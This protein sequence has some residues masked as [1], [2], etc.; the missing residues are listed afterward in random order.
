[1]LAELVGWYA[2]QEQNR[3]RYP[4]IRKD[5]EA[6]Y[7][8]NGGRTWHALRGVDLGGGG[9][10][11]MSDHTI[12]SIVV[13]IVLHLDEEVPV[14]ALPV[15][16]TQVNEGKKTAYCYGMQFISIDARHWEAVMHWIT[17]KA[18]E[19]DGKMPAVR[20]SDAEVA[21]L[22]PKDLRKN[23]LAEL[24]TRNR[25]DAANQGTLQFDYGGVTALNGKPMHRFTLHS[26]AKA[27][28]IEMRYTT[29]I[30]CDDEGQEIIVL[31]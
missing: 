23:L 10:C 7:S 3:R 30:L 16:N 2:G 20:I 31:N 18:Y 25:V 22:L 14:R 11:V 5:Y 24:A 17:G 13:D 8:V 21:R 4:R 29:R 26:K 1:M 19:D 9:M 28:G 27:M 6:K 15:W 12:H